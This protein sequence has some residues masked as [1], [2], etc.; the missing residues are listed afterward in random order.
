[1]LNFTF[2]KQLILCTSV[3]YTLDAMAEKYRPTNPQDLDAFDAIMDV[4]EGNHPRTI[5]SRY[6]SLTTSEQNFIW[7]YYKA[8]EGVEYINGRQVRATGKRRHFWVRSAYQHSQPLLDRNKSTWDYAFVQKYIDELYI[9]AFKESTELSYHIPFFLF[10]NGVSNSD[11]SKFQPYLNKLSLDEYEIIDPI[12]IV[13]KLPGGRASGGG[14]FPPHKMG[15]WLGRE[16]NTGITDDEIYDYFLDRNRGIIAITKASLY[17]SY[18]QYTLLHEVAHSIDHY[19]DII[20]A[21]ATIADFA[22][23]KY[24]QP[25]VGEYAAEVYSRYLVNPNRVCRRDHLPANETMR[26]CS[27]RTILFLNTAPA[28]IDRTL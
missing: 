28:F 10:S 4:F 19:F 25:R 11:I 1:M 2:L 15:Q 24:K 7:D 13:D 14:Y 23:Q 18:Y 20:P 5:I 27:Q 21:G 8:N 22:G 26:S 16:H 17:T 6:A 12:V 3:F 9:T